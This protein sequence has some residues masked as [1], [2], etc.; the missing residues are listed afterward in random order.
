MRPKPTTSFN[1]QDPSSKT[2]VTDITHEE[3]DMASSSTR[4]P[5]LEENQ[6]VLD[7]LTH[8]DLISRLP[9]IDARREGVVDLINTLSSLQKDADLLY[10]QY[11]RS[12]LELD[13]RMFHQL[14]KNVQSRRRALVHSGDEHFWHHVILNHEVLSE[15]VTEKDA[16]ALLFLED[17]S[18]ELATIDKPT[19]GIGEEK[20]LY[21]IGSYCLTF[22]FRENPFFE[23]QQLQKTYIMHD[24]DHEELAYPIG[25]TIHWK[26]GKN[27]TIRSVRKKRKDGTPVLKTYNADSFFNFFN[28]PVVP[29]DDDPYAADGTMME[30]IEDVLDADYELGE[31]IRNELIPRAFMHYIDLVKY[32]AWLDTKASEHSDEE[33]EDTDEEENGD[34]GQANDESDDHDIAPAMRRNTKYAGRTPSRQH[35]RKAPPVSNVENHTQEDEDFSDD[36]DDEGPTRMSFPKGA[37]RPSRSRYSD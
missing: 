32:E 36:D 23:N 21:S 11:V 16:Q 12:R 9:P 33:D 14:G 28:P 18:C 15:N 5:R 25:T 1:T 3:Q 27:L 35:R 24:N 4:T 34:E 2:V 26:P 29:N 8:D 37:G 30:E 20:K 19:L 7:T 17:I 10:D 13:A 31:C 6:H 22:R